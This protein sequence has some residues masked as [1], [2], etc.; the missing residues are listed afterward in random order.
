M[1]LKNPMPQRIDPYSAEQSTLAHLDKI[2]CNKR[3]CLIGSSIKDLDLSGYDIIVRLNDWWFHDED[4]C[5]ILFHVGYSNKFKLSFLFDR[6]AFTEQIKMI[7]AFDNIGGRNI[8]KLAAYHGKSVVLIKNEDKEIHS[9]VKWFELRGTYPSTGLIAFYL[10]SQFPCQKLHYTGANLYAHEPEHQ[11]WLRHNPIGHVHWFT[12]LLKLSRLSIG[13]DLKE[14][15]AY[16][17]KR[18]HE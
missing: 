16:W 14:G 3:V 18:S 8:K 7:V 15:I 13:E 10:L 6:P 17:E 12:E 1:Q 2:L 11:G 5:D 9:L 4:R